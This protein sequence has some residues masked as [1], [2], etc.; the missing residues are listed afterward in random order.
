MNSG[1]TT[2]RFEDYL[3]ET[4]IFESSDLPGSS[5]KGPISVLVS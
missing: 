2:A 5:V 4:R 3:E 1:L